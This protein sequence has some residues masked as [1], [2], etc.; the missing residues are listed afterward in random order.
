MSHDE[1][2]QLLGSLGQPSTVERRLEILEKLI[3]YWHGGFLPD[4]LRPEESLRNLR[5]PR[6]LRWLY[7]RGADRSGFFS[8]QNQLLGPD[9]LEIVDG[10]LVFYVENQGVYLWAIEEKENRRDVPGQL[11]L[12]F[13]DE[14]DSRPIET[15]DE[16][17][18]VWG[19]FNGKNDPWELEE[20]RLSEF[21]IQA[22]LFEAIQSAPHGASA[23]W[24]NQDLLDR[25]TAPLKL[26][27]LGAW[28]WP[29]YPHRFWAGGGT[30]VS[31]CPNGIVDGEL[32]YSIWVG[33]KAEEPLQYLKV[34][35]DK[36]WEHKTF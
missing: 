10:R 28:R 17:P 25:V 14:H 30:F 8:R 35:V 20:V 23:S 11:R 5:L 32:G 26:V 34:I 27:P 15:N 9:D 7:E 36:S 16:D 33:A 18:P 22:C 12:P 6:P 1:I 31:A 4:H 24:G 21:L 13:M 29:S 3:R 19:R 2:D